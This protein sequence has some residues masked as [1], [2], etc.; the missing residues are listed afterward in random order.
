MT[1]L[2]KRSWVLLAAALVFGML[3][4]GAVSTCDDI[5]LLE[6]ELERAEA[7]QAPQW[8]RDGD[9]LVFEAGRELYIIDATGAD[10]RRISTRLPSGRP[11]EF[12]ID[13]APSVSPDG[14]TITFTTMRYSNGLQHSF[15]IATIDVNGRNDR[16]LT[17]DES[18]DTNPAWSPDGSRIAFYS[19]RPDDYGGFRLYVMS[20]NGSNVRNLVPDLFVSKA[21]AVWSPDSQKLA[22]FGSGGLQTLTSG[23][24]GYKSVLYTVNVDGTDLAKISENVLE[25]SRVEQEYWRLPAWSPNGN[26]IAFLEFGGASGAPDSEAGLYVANA[27][28][29]DSHRLAE[30][31]AARNPRWTA[32]GDSILYVDGRRLWRVAANGSSKPHDLWGKD[33]S[34]GPYLVWSP[35]GSRLASKSIPGVGNTAFEVIS[36]DGSTTG[37]LLEQW[38]GYRR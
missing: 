13:L 10:L 4:T 25:F 26:R 16:R 30:S 27:D 19:D 22:F 31:R 38:E 12:D 37:Y 11:G 21:P 7:F 18:L 8:A 1:S 5:R 9:S 14:S 33:V 28:G 6:R 15:D 20:R 24:Q 23:E 17:Q 36:L 35:D 32:N 29:T 3:A 2:T 34:L